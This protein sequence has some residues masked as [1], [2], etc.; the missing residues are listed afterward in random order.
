[1][2]TKRY[3]VRYT[4]YDGEYEYSDAVTHDLDPKLVHD[5]DGGCDD[6]YVLN[7][8]MGYI[9]AEDHLDPSPYKDG[10]YEDNSDYR[11]YELYSIKEIAEADLKILNK[12]GV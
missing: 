10:L 7:T 3:F 1:M 5:A 9:D 2:K 4:I 6:A 12:Y 8:I 11:L